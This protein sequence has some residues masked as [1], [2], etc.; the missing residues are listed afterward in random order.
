[1]YCIGLAVLFAAI[2]MN[3]LAIKLG[4]P[5]WYDLIRAIQMHGFLVAIQNVSVSQLLF[6]TVVY[7]LVLGFV[8][9]I[10]ARSIT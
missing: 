6:L 9:M 7:P 3:T 8:A 10:T 2:V 1:M 5:T 4:V